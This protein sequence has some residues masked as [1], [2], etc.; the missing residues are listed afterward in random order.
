VVSRVVLVTG[1]SRNIGAAIAR[2]FAR[3]GYRVVAVARSAERVAEALLGE[4]RDAISIVEAD[5][6]IESDVERLADDVI[7]SH[8]GVDILINNAA[9]RADYPLA[10]HP[11][12]EFRRMID[13]AVVA[14]F[15]LVRR[16]GPGMAERGWGRIV[17]LAGLTGQQGSLHRPGVAAS[18]AGVI[19]M[20]K[21]LARELGPSGV[22]VNVLSP[23]PVATDRHWTTPEEEEAGSAAIERRKLD[24][25]V[26]RLT[27]VDEVVAL[28]RYLTSDDAAPI[29]GQ[30]VSINGGLLMP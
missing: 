6:A 11:V 26:R 9:Y 17:S 8:G 1:A 4:E 18:K 16:F 30:T 24:I 19:G 2:S 5:L 28:C 7:D 29:T 12:D 25:P 14:A 15:Q 10:D 23:G 13:V 21:A 20:S 3:D 22:T 27:E